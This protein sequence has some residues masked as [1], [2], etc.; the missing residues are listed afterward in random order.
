MFRVG[1]VVVK[2]LGYFVWRGG[3]QVKFVDSGRVLNGTGLFES[4]VDVGNSKSTR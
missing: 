4:E 3:S 2:C 1:R